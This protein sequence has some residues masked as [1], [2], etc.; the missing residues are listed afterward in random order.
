[1]GQKIY[2]LYPLDFIIIQLSFYHKYCYILLYA[3][4]QVCYF[5]GICINVYVQFSYNVFKDI[6]RILL[7]LI[8]SHN[9][10]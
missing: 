10:T 4:A 5:D 8:V 3:Y 1:M 2:I 7:V 6:R 9:L